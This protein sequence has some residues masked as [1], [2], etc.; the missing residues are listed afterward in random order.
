[1]TPE[2]ARAVAAIQGVLAEVGD[3]LACGSLD[4][5]L[6]AEPALCAAVDRLARAGES[7]L[8]RAGKRTVEDAR[9][10]LL[11]CRRLGASLIEFTRISLDPHG[12]QA[13]SRAG[14]M[15]ALES[16]SNGPGRLAGAM[17]EAR[18]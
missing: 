13:Y 14:R 7:P 6:A 3:A 9:A 10:A 11:R 17:L 16:P 5:L 18:G 1:M 12:G 8:D 4:R 15:P 2:Q